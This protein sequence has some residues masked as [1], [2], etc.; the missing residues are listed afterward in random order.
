[1]SGPHESDHE[2]S[3]PL[4]EQSVLA[5][6]PRTRPQRSSARRAAAR[7]VTARDDATSNGGA[8]ARTPSKPAR[9]KA[10]A[11]PRSKANAKPS[12]KAASTER[13]ARANTTRGAAERKR[14]PAR[15]AARAGAAEAVPSQ[16]FETEGDGGRGPVEPPGGTELVAS[17]VEIV[18]EFA[19]AGLSRGERL[20]K[21]VFSRLSP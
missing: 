3:A 7:Q 21:D 16:G 13:R 18:G 5:N 1:M 20:L 14:A 9:T 6:L 2:A 12:A 17:A 10:K 8:G 15:R 19:K 4:E 11:K